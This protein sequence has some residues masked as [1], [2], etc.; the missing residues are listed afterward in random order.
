MKAN[1]IRKG[2]VLLHNK[3]PH[4]V[5]EFHHVTPGKGQAVV[6]TKLRNL[7]SGSQT[8]VRFG[9]T[10]G[11]ELADV[12]SFKATYLYSDGGTY[13][14]MNSQDYEQL[15]LT[16]ELLGSDVHFLQEQ[17]EVEITTFEEN[18]IGIKLPQTVVLTIVETE[19]ELKGATASNSPKPATTDTGHTLSVPAFVKEGEK[20]VVST[21]TGDYLSRA[22]K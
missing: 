8:E 6:Q 7:I 21:D 19:P 1:D 13:Y 15:P 5:M 20:V 3:A 2:T 10:E 16:D 9:S 12:F 18:P 14:F 17:M 4:R 22:E 11:V